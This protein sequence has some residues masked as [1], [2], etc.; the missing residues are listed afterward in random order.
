MNDAIAKRS[1]AQRLVDVFDDPIL[2]L[3]LRAA[4]RR[5][6][7]FWLQT[8]LLSV[9]AAVVLFTMWGLTETYRDDT[10]EIGRRTFL[11]FVGVELALVT[12]VFPA[13]SCTAI[14]DERV[15]KSLDLLLTTRLTPGRIVLGKMLAAFVYGLLFIVATLPLVALTF[16]FGGVTPGQIALTYGVLVTDAFVVTLFA[17]AV[18]SSMGSTLRSV[19]VSY[20]GLVL[21]VIP[22]LAP[23][24]DTTYLL[25]V[26]SRESWPTR[27]NASGI[28][29]VHVVGPLLHE[30]KAVAIRDAIRLYDGLETALYWGTHAVFYAAFCSLLF[31]VAR[32]RLAPAGTNRSTPFRV[33]FVGALGAGLACVLTAYAHEARPDPRPTLDLFLVTELVIFVTLLFGVLGF[34]AEDPAVPKRVRLATERHRGLRAVLRAFYPGTRQGERFVIWTTLFAQVAIGAVFLGSL[35]IERLANDA[36][37]REGVHILEWGAG[38]VLAFI[39]FLVELAVLLAC[40]IRHA[41]QARLWVVVY[42]V[43]ATLYPVFWL[44]VNDPLGKPRLYEAYFLSPWTVAQSLIERD[45]DTR[46]QLVLFGPSGREIRAA[47]NALDSRFDD[48]SRAAAPGASLV[49]AAAGGNE[50]E[51]T[52]RE[53]RAR[54]DGSVS[55]HVIDLTCRHVETALARAR[56]ELEKAKASS[57]V[58]FVAEKIVTGEVKQEER[59]ALLAELTSEGVPIHEVAVWVY[60]VLGLALWRLNRKRLLRAELEGQAE[61]IAPAPAAP[62]PA[63]AAV[64]TATQAPM[65]S[66]T[67]APAA[68]DSPTSVPAAAESPRTQ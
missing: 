20:V 40:E 50:L 7:F 26:F 33:W 39:F 43:F 59:A 42:L 12:L 64:S 17:L 29:S 54:R 3:Q 15:N 46:R 44:N 2:L 11:V 8:G 10:S 45:R 56:A 34:S 18:S 38:F 13:F 1:A 23:L 37:V 63:P 55:E 68:A 48:L 21:V 67:V 61:A 52:R 36:S 30:S 6:R 28:L 60:A 27:G 25:D 31:L 51:T 32:H 22:A 65:A 9:L 47:T 24:I 19:L 66:A 14:T 58:P 57:D 53:L 16:L 49:P 41:T 62:T 35:E 5:N 4:F